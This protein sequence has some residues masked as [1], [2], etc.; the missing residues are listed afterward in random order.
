[1]APMAKKPRSTPKE[2]AP[3]SY[4]VLFSDVARVIEDARRAAA[5]S[6]NAVMTATYRLVGQRIVEGD[7]GG[8]ARAGYAEAL[9]DRW[10]CRDFTQRMLIPGEM[11]CASRIVSVRLRRDE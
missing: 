11:S 3:A 9:L 2:V 10:G 7:Q 8:R 5:R 1:M 6:V 4:D